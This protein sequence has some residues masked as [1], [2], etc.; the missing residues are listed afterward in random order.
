MKF[1]TINYKRAIPF[2]VFLYLL[3]LLVSIITAL[4][5]GVNFSAGELAPPIVSIISIISSLVFGVGFSWWYFHF[6]DSRKEIA[7]NTG[8]LL[9][10]V[11]AIINVLIEFAFVLP[12][13]ILGGN[14]QM[15]SAYD[16]LRFFW[17]HVAVIVIS[18][19]VYGFSLKP[20]LIMKKVNKSK[21]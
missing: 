21:K 17:L 20:D 13:I 18:S 2:G 5:I 6:E 10:I 12:F 8:F 16:S 11:Y 9:G 4:I 15:V 7:T 19:M 3:T 1:K 14:P